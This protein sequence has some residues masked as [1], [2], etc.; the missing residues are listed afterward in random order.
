[1]Q[2]AIIW[3]P[4]ANRARYQLKTVMPMNTDVNKV[5]ALQRIKDK[6][7]RKRMEM[8]CLNRARGINELEDNMSS[9]G[10]KKTNG[11]IRLVCFKCWNAN[12][13]TD[14][15]ATSEGKPSS[16]F[17]KKTAILINTEKM[18]EKYL[19]HWEKWYSKVDPY[20]YQKL[21]GELRRMRPPYACLLL[22]LSW[23]GRLQQQLFN[24]FLDHRCLPR[25]LHL[26]TAAEEPE[27]EGEE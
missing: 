24:N 7:I 19:T 1:M 11:S 9:N 25:S 27:T 23:S 12:E 8:D 14:K 16:A 20:I 2:Q 21:T 5:M 6:A 22:L 15:Y 26:G 4:G 10:A 13:N 3:V 18:R 17:R